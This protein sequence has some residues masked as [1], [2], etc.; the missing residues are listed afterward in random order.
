MSGLGHNKGPTMEGGAAWRK[1]C[2]KRARADLL[3]KL[4]LEVIR[5]RVNRAKELGLEYKTYASVR[6][7]TGRDIVAFLFS[8]NALGL[9]RTAADLPQSH[10][11]MLIAQRNCGRLLASYPPLDPV[12]VVEEIAQTHGTEFLNGI[13]APSFTDSW[14]DIRAQMGATL[15]R[16]GLH[17][18]SVLVVGD[19]MLE[20]EWCTAGRMAGYLKAGEYFR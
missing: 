15:R 2:W 16:D 17:P 12:K 3:P 4:P 9:R 6:A 1:H 14:S 13:S 7:T 11:D 18:A 5:I 19:T 8:S 20:R 10:A